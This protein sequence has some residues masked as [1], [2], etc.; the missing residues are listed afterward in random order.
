MGCYINIV[1]ISLCIQIG[2]S[3]FSNRTTMP[4]SKSVSAQ[5][6]KSTKTESHI[7]NIAGAYIY[8]YIY[9]YHHHF[10]VCMFLVALN[11]NCI[12]F[13][14]IQWIHI[15]TRAY[16]AKSSICVRKIYQQMFEKFVQ[17][18]RSQKLVQL[19]PLCTV[20][21]LLYNS[22][23]LSCTFAQIC[24]NVLTFACTNKL[25]YIVCSFQHFAA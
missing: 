6:C 12:S 11:I 4:I 22:G 14:Y 5:T 18:C 1:I 2:T 24:L 10:Y 15:H 25:C 3:S 21:I 16:S 7:I 19:P 13:L 8:I 23:Q 9:H 17:A 20:L